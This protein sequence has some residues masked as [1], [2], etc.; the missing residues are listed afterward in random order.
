M[1][2]WAGDTGGRRFELDVAG[3]YSDYSTSGGITS[4]KAGLNFQVAEFLRLRATVSRDVREATF[5]ERFDVQGGGGSIQENAIAGVPNPGGPL[6][7]VPDHEHERRQPGPEARDRRYDYRGHR[8]P[9][10]RHRPAVLDGLVRHRSRRRDR[11]DRRARHLERVHELGRGEP[12]VLERA[13]R[14]C[15]QRRRGGVQPVSEHQQRA[16]PRHRLRGFVEQGR[17]LVQQSVTSR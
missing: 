2:L 16:R 6:H 11:S 13:P 14:P 8:D 5:A 3:R 15:H 9:A 1:P 12:C 17:G 4:W 7:D 10:A